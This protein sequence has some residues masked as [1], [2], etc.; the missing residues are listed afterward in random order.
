MSSILKKIIAITFVMATTPVVAAQYTLTELSPAIAGTS[1]SAFGINNSGQVVG[2]TNYIS[3]TSAT[4]WSNGNTTNLGIISN[5]DYSVAYSINDTGQ[6]VGY[7]GNGGVPTLWANGSATNLGYFPNGGNDAVAYG[8]NNSGQ[9]VGYDTN[10]NPSNN[11]TATEW[12]NG[13]AVN[14]TGIY[15]NNNINNSYSTAYAINNS[16]QIVGY[17]VMGLIDLLV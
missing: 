9:V 3:G 14:L 17:T 15:G 4:E 6:V 13:G 5:G 7:S 11:I 10:G 12:S 8:I 2:S 1:S 16:G